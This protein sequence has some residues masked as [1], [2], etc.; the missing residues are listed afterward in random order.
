MMYYTDDKIIIIRGMK[1]SDVQIITDEEIAQG[2]AADVEK[3]K[4]RLQHQSKGKSISPVAEYN[5]NIAGMA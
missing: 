3:Y 4:T 5:G 1:Q 2:W